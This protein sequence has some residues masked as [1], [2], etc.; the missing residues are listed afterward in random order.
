MRP[1]FALALAI[2]ATA[3]ASIFIR[4]AVA[5][6]LVIAAYRLSLAALLLAPLASLKSR[7]EMRRLAR[8]DW[9]LAL[10]AGAFLALHFG[11]WITSLQLTTVAASVTIV[12]SAP[13]WVALIS[14]A[15]LPERVS[16]LMWLGVLV[17]VIG[18]IFISGGDVAV[19]ANALTGDLLALL[20][21]WGGAGYFLIG[22]RLR[23]HLSL[24]AY[25]TLVYSVAAILLVAVALAT[26]QPL[27]GYSAQ[28]YALFV[29]L[30]LI[31]QIVGHSSL[32]YAL[33]YLSATFVSIT[34]LGEPIGATLLAF[35]ILGET[36]PPSV[37]F[38]GALVLI[39]I[40]LAGRGESR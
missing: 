9:L 29:L 12:T 24:L 18:G 16:R 40:A 33:R 37:L 2:I 10:G 26:G 3:L 36:P 35:L 8:R 15:L 31:P 19:G 22:R 13:I 1:Y 7:S 34:T 14:F 17:A 21:A 28:T 30:A 11:A 38:G 39:G 6:A 20:G 32:N 25:I 27:V 4:L 23:P 5:P